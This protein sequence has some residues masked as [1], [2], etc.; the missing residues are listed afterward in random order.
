MKNNLLN[1]SLM[2]T[3]VVQGISLLLIALL[4]GIMIL[5]AFNADVLSNYVAV[6]D[7]ITFNLSSEA[8]QNRLHQVPDGYFYFQSIGALGVCIILLLI[9]TRFKTIIESIR[10]L[11]TF[12]EE[13]VRNFRTIGIYFL[14]WL[15]WSLPDLS[16][17]D[18]Q[19]GFSLSIS[20]NYAIWALV[21]FVLAEIFAE[22][23]RLMQENQLT[24]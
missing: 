5:W 13:N 23:N 14:I 2:I 1:I 21:C 9:V 4:T 19:T 11:K 17:S 6:D 22:G 20:F 12:R 16:I 15:I 8:Q 18:G 10:S 3:R 7:G 24:I